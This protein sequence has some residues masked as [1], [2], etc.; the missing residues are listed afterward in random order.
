VDGTAL[1]YSIS[2]V[3]GMVMIFFSG[4]YEAAAVFYLC[5]AMS[6][7]KAMM[8]P[9]YIPLDAMGFFAHFMVTMYLALYIVGRRSA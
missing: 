2:A 3:I 8:L 4:R 1:T 9:M 6:N 7:M 5:V